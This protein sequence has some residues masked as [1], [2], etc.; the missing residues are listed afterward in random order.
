MALMSH[1]SQFKAVWS[2]PGATA[3]T[4]VT[5]PNI[6]FN[7]G[8]TIASGAGNAGYSGYGNYNQYGGLV[9]VTN[10]GA[11]TAIISAGT[12][13][14]YQPTTFNVARGTSPSD[15]TVSGAINGFTGYGD[16]SGLT[17]TGGGIMTLTGNN[18]YGGSTTISAGT[19][20]VARRGRPWRRQLC[21]HHL[22]R[23]QQRPGH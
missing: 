12:F 2:P 3:A 9:S 16:T 21:G 6:V 17:L 19:L 1:C 18:T 15:L 11:T 14:L 8:G 20:V 13:N 4:H 22:H 5:L 23:R 7:G 10:P